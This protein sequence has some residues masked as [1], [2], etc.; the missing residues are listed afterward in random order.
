MVHVGMQAGGDVMINQHGCMDDQCMKLSSIF[1]GQRRSHF[2]SRFYHH[3][4]LISQSIKPTAERSS[5]IFH[6]SSITRDPSPANTP[7]MIISVFRL[8]KNTSD[9]TVSPVV[10]NQVCLTKLARGDGAPI[11]FSSL[12]SKFPQVPD[13]LQSVRSSNLPECRQ[14]DIPKS[15]I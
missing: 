1:V 9:L 3:L 11:F 10:G 5:Y 13:R 14:T 2:S 12:N 8:S 7:N 15:G 6:D 4:E